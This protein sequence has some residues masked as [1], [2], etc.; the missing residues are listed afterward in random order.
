VTTWRDYTPWLLPSDVERIER[1]ERYGL[2]EYP[3]TFLARATAG[4]NLWWFSN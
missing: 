3:L 1:S 4:N 2:P